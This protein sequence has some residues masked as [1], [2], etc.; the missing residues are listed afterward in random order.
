MHTPELAIPL[1]VLAVVVQMLVSLFWFRPLFVS[2]FPI[3]RRPI[4]LKRQA[5]T[6]WV[7][8]TLQSSRPTALVFCKL[9]EDCVGL[10]GSLFWGVTGVHGVI[11]TGQAGG[12]RAVIAWPI[13]PLYAFFLWLPWALPSGGVQ[14]A[15]FPAL[16]VL[17]IPIIDLVMMQR[18]I[19]QLEG[20][21]SAA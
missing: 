13:A 14:S 3:Y 12:F 2:G 7:M 1:I 20:R 18:A 17:A 19:K 16:I 5:S 11:T 21:A 15:I 10:R 8:G 4:D 9:S 6:D